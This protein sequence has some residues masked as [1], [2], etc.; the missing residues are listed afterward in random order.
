MRKNGYS[1]D[2]FSSLTKFL[3]GETE[4][5]GKQLMEKYKYRYDLHQPPCDEQSLVDQWLYNRHRSCMHTD[6]CSAYVLKGF[7]RP[8]LISTAVQ[9]A[10]RTLLKPQRLIN[11]PR[12]L[13]EE[14]KQLSN[15]RLGL[16]TGLFSSVFKVN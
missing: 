4:I 8:F 14:I 13:I 1:N 6:A 11:E 7:F 12:I 16:F 10:S 15:Y 3:L 2:L 9:L 5:Q